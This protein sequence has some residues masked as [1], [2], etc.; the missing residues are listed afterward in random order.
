MCLTMLKIL[1]STVFRYL[2]YFHQR[3]DCPGERNAYGESGA[4]VGHKSEVDPVIMVKGRIPDTGGTGSISA[5]L[6]GGGFAQ[7]G[8]TAESGTAGKNTTD[9]INRVSEGA[10][11]KDDLSEEED[12][13][14]PEGEGGSPS[15]AKVTGRTGTIYSFQG[16][17]EDDDSEEPPLERRPPTPVPGADLFILFY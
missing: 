14:P 6:N 9:N 16:E 4:Q 8:T 3:T 2:F 11:P 17:E 1:H 7:N 5:T 12:P 10:E 15:P 13:T